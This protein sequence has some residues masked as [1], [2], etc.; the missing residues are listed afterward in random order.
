MWSWVFG[1]VGGVAALWL[2]RTSISFAV[3][4]APRTID[5]YQEWTPFRL[6]ALA[7]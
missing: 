7:E 1:L 5:V 3:A 6:A 4:D 2:Y